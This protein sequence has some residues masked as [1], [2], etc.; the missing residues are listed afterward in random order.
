MSSKSN[1]M[2]V[3]SPVTAQ[4]QGILK[5]TPSKES[6]TVERYNKVMTRVSDLVSEL[7]GTDVTTLHKNSQQAVNATNDYKKKYTEL[8]NYFMFLFKS[9]EK[10]DEIEIQL[11]YLFAF[12]QRFDLVKKIMI[13][14]VPSKDLKTIKLHKLLRADSVDQQ[15]L[16]AEFIY[17]LRN[18]KTSKDGKTFAKPYEN[19]IDYVVSAQKVGNSHT[20]KAR[21]TYQRM[22]ALFRTENYNFT[23]IGNQDFILNPHM[24]V[25]K[26]SGTDVGTSI[27]TLANR[28]L[29][30]REVA[31]VLSDF[32]NRMEEDENDGLRKS[33]SGTLKIVE[34]GFD[35]EE[36][37][38]NVKKVTET[39]STTNSAPPVVISSPTTVIFEEVVPTE[40]IVIVEKPSA[41]ERDVKPITVVENVTINNN[42]TITNVN[43][44]QTTTVVAASSENHYASK[45]ETGPSSIDR[46]LIEELAKKQ[47]EMKKA[48]KKKVAFEDQQVVKHEEIVVHKLKP[49]PVLASVEIEEE[50][51]QDIIV[52]KLKPIAEIDVPQ[53]IVKE[54]IVLHKLKPVPV[55]I[56]Q[57]IVVHKVQP[58]P[59]EEI[60]PHV[61]KED[62]VVH[63]VKPIP[64]EVKPEIVVHKVKPVPVE[65]KPEIVVH[66]VKPIPVEVK[67]S[68]EK[69]LEH[70]NNH[71]HEQRIHQ[72]S[73]VVS[74]T[75]TTTT[76]TKNNKT[77][78]ARQALSKMNFYSLAANKFGDVAPPSDS[79]VTDPTTPVDPTSPVDPSEPTQDQL[80]I[81]IANILARLQVLSSNLTDFTQT[82]AKI[83]FD[84]KM[85]LEDFRSGLVKKAHQKVSGLSRRISANSL[86]MLQIVT[87]G[88]NSEEL[89]E[90]W[91]QNMQ[92]LSEMSTDASSTFSDDEVNQLNQ[93]EDDTRDAEYKWKE[94]VELQN[95]FNALQLYQN[96]NKM[97]EHIKTAANMMSHGASSKDHHVLVEGLQDKINDISEKLNVIDVDTLSNKKMLLSSMVSLSG[98]AEMISTISAVKLIENK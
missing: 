53:S 94:Y 21:E 77:D 34:F 5:K 91:R 28:D 19:Y 62:I 13:E 43:N 30:N 98:L 56:K 51:N 2:T 79:S 64:V 86:Q 58:A 24:R 70:Q 82:L 72:H 74:S 85:D 65:V 42:S 3:G 10:S 23:Y 80:Q 67:Q 9:L 59:V 6:Q 7:D 31:E 38:F 25:I 96:L 17:F 1:N 37:K 27:V 14:Q 40:E 11:R 16:A 46:K 81:I 69:S 54:E 20:K 22:E 78:F 15:L 75:V 88:E 48:E 45:K 32:H 4:P 90:K 63:K 61:V 47:Q 57:E 29:A 49:V 12:L 39:G 95:Q 83:W 89:G 44:Q 33:K 76:T 18:I 26:A 35:M 68:K 36:L 97:E 60:P 50:I 84:K 92:D 66:K 87:G 8:I 55:E 41:P 52:H 93:K 73:T 71:D